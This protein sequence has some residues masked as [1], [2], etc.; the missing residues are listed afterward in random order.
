[1]VESGSPAMFT[2]AA[3]SPAGGGTL[4]YQWRM[5]GVNLSDGGAVSGALTATL[6]IAPAAGADNAASF[7]CIVSNACG[8]TRSDPA[9][10]GVTPDCPA[11]FNMDGGIDGSDVEA[12]F[13]RWENGC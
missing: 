6:T 7:D 12:F 11:D 4:T 13:E 9:G 2:I 5:N 1:M 10:L 3:T 8:S